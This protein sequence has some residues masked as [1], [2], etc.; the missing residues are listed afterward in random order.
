MLVGSAPQAAD[1]AST[2]G[3]AQ[4]A[5]Q[6]RRHRSRLDRAR[7]GWIGMALMAA[8]YSAAINDVAAGAPSKGRRA[9][10]SDAA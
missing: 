7:V 1:A 5:P 6:A 4:A 10:K 9:K 8:A 3:H 2:S